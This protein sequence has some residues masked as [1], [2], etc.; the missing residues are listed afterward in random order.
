MAKIQGLDKLKKKL[1]ELPDDVK[2]AIEPALLKGANEIADLQRALAPKITGELV[3]SITV[4]TP[5]TTE[6]GSRRVSIEAEAFYADWVERGRRKYNGED[7]NPYFWPGYRLA[8]K[9]AQ[10]RIKRAIS[11]AAKRSFNQ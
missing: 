11:T 3:N 6:D 7:A 9:K 1:R 5:E 4:H 10:A 8:K 2:D